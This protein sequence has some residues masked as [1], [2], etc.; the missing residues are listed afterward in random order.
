MI[1]R[2]D[3]LTPPADEDLELAALT[4]EITRRL[5]RGEIVDANEY[6]QAHPGLAAPIRG[7]I[8]MLHTLVELGRA[9]HPVPGTNGHPKGE[10]RR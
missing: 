3:P 5:E 6:Q 4:E 10:E 2:R 9:A 7:L 1:D 8:P